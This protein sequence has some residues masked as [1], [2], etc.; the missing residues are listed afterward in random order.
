MGRGKGGRIGWLDDSLVLPLNPSHSSPQPCEHRVV[1]ATLPTR[2]ISPRDVELNPLPADAV[3]PLKSDNIL[4]HLFYFQGTVI[5]LA[6]M[7]P[8]LNAGELKTCTT[9]SQDLAIT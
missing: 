2:Y 7:R 5:A 4:S 1:L 3:R 6:E 9:R 8:S